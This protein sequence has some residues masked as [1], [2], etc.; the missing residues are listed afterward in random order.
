MRFLALC[1]ALAACSSAE[2][3][4]PDASTN[5]D[6]PIADV[7]VDTAPDVAPADAPVDVTPNA[8]AD[9]SPEASVDVASDVVRDAAADVRTCG[10]PYILECEVDGSLTCVN[11]TTGRMRSDGT[12]IHCG[13]C[14][15]TCAS[16][17]A[18]LARVCERL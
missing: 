17:F 4:T 6:A 16:G 9:A 10:V 3:V 13:A 2:P 11:I 1:L 14:G 18:C 8:S 7:A 5:P 15:V 12:T